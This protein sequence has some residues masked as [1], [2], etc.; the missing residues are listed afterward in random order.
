M[1]R[2]MQIDRN[3][4]ERLEA[5][6]RRRPVVVLAGPRGAGKR[7]LAESVSAGW[8]RVSLADAA[9][10]A[11]AAAP[12]EFVAGLVGA[13]RLE[14]VHHAPGLVAAVVAAARR[15]PRPGRFLLVSGVDPY[16]LPGSSELPPELVEMLLLWGVSQGERRGVREG[17]VDAV[18]AEK[19]LPGLEG[20][21]SGRGELLRLALTGAYP[22]GLG[23]RREEREERLGARLGEVLQSEIPAMA[24]V[25]RP[26]EVTRL[27]SV[28]ARSAG[29][30]LNFAALSRASGIPAST[31]K[32]HLAL[33]EAAFL[34]QAVP[35]WS[36]I[37]Q[38]RLAKSPKLLLTDTSLL[39]RLAEIGEAR[40]GSDRLAAG[41]L[42][43]NFVGM[44]LH[45]QATWSRTEPRIHHLRTAGGQAVDFVLADRAGHVVGVE[46][47]ASSAA[48]AR[49]ARHLR[50]LADGL[51]RRF[52]RGIV[53]HTG[54]RHGALGPRI[55]ALPI[56]ALWRLGASR[57]PAPAGR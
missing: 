38:R 51:G 31:V 13:V 23:V 54:E 12:A 19:A 43:E 32:R 18:F 49:D 3:L 7:A 40:A 45:R 16:L 9:T 4:K 24:R 41:M 52:R 5:A 53:L 28:V 26:E 47:R 25:A 14:G 21:A 1:L 22:G 29:A 35:A 2:G 48:G 57:H 34:L 36:T 55:E 56:D 46:V 50:A 30:L 27:L 20:R 8:R 42:L 11:A 10:R 39:A 44:E 15:D 37:H 17:F 6:L 33:L